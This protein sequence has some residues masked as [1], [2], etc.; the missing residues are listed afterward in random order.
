MLPAFSASSRPAVSVTTTAKSLASVERVEKEVRTISLAASLTTER[1]RVQ[2]TSR[3]I[4]SVEMSRSC[5][6]FVAVIFLFLNRNHE[7]ARVHLLDTPLGSDDERRP[8][9]LDEHGARSEE[10]TSELQSLMRISYAV[11]CLK[12]KNKI[13]TITTTIPTI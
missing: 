11:F 7:V 2:N 6:G 8:R 10:H 9:I 3:K 4:G 1:T 12:K 13:S 5:T